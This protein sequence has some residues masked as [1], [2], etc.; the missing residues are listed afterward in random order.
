[1]STSKYCIGICELHN[2]VIHG[3]NIYS[4]PNIKEHYIVM[5][6]FNTYQKYLN[7]NRCE[8]NDNE[9]I[10]D[11]DSITSNYEEDNL[12][13]LY[14]YKYSILKRSVAFMNKQHEIIRNYHKI[15]QSFNYIQPHI[16][17]CIYLPEQG[18]ECIAILKT[19]WL[20]IIQRNWKRVY[21]QKIAL[22][23]SIPYLR[24]REI[25]FEKTI[26]IPGIRGML[27]EMYYK[28][29]GI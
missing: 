20:K 26:Y 11:D 25:G 4:S 5:E 28:N 10:E 14:K 19:F 6:K 13:D 29:K 18:E 15:I 7:N 8:E 3:F 9:S 1:M 23:K 12:I 16:V 2:E 17:E 21:K 22:S 24:L 27:S